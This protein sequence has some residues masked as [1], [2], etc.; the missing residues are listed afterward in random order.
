MPVWIMG[1]DIMH[2]W[3]TQDDAAVDCICDVV[4]VVCMCV[5]CLCVIIKIISYYKM[6]KILI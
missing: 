3:L 2:S 5:I 1:I 4:H 6:T